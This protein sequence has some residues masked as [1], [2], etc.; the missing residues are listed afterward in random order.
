MSVQPGRVAI[1]HDRFSPLC[2]QIE[3]RQRVNRVNQCVK[4]PKQQQQQKMFSENKYKL[5]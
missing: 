3:T 5:I 1:W 4:E 2:A